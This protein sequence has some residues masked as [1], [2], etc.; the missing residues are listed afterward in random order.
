MLIHEHVLFSFNCVVFSVAWPYM[1][2]TEDALSAKSKGKQWIINKHVHHEHDIFCSTF[3]IIVLFFVCP[4]TFGQ[5]RRCIVSKIKGQDVNH[6]QKLFNH[7][8][9][10]YCS[11]ILCQQRICTVSKIKLEAMKIILQKKS[12]MNMTYFI[13]IAGQ[14]P[15]YLVKTEDTPSANVPGSTCWQ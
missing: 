13:I 1:V 15:P 10:I 5:H 2:K 8:H 6:K 12:T 11:A 9:D 7:E 14:W 3:V 4:T